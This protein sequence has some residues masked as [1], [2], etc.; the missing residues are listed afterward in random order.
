[1]KE[2]TKHLYGIC[3]KKISNDNIISQNIKFNEQ[4]QY[5][6]LLC[7]KTMIKKFVLYFYSY[8]SVFI[9]KGVQSV[10]LHARIIV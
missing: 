8:S 1:M 3:K 10:C 7:Q 9:F 4:S 6:N 5:R 2:D